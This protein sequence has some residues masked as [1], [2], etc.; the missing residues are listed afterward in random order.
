MINL[1]RYHPITG[2]WYI[3][4]SCLPENAAAWLVIFQKDEPNAHFKLGKRKPRG[5]P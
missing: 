4:R 1:Y 2:Y 3:E 5:G